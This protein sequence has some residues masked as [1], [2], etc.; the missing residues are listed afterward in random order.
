MSR[1]LLERR[2]LHV[3]VRT[4]DQRTHGGLAELVQS[5]GVRIDGKAACCL[6]LALI[7]AQGDLVKSRLLRQYDLREDIVGDVGDLL[8]LYVLGHEVSL[9]VSYGRRQTH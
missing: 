6:E 1:L 7:P 4:R 8:C 3:D 9:S 2:Q 5:A